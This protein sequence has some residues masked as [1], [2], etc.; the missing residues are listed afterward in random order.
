MRL[1]EGCMEHNNKDDVQLACDIEGWKFNQLR[2][3]AKQGR[4]YALVGM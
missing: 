4:Q 1:S 3:I 2:N